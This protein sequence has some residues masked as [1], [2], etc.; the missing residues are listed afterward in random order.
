MHSFLCQFRDNK[1]VRAKQILGL[2]PYR[3]L[4][5]LQ[6]CGETYNHVGKTFSYLS[7]FR[8]APK[9]SVQQ[10]LPQSSLEDERLA[11]DLFNVSPME[12]SNILMKPVEAH[13][14]LALESDD[15]DQL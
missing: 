1:L 13:I 8:N 4:S 6:R 3:I 9:G 7:S 15:V 10:I 2:M 12:R 5:M 14:T 11:D